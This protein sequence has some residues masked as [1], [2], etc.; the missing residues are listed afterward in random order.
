MLGKPEWFTYRKLGWGI[1]PRSW[2]GFAYAGVFLALVIALAS[3]PLPEN[4]KNIL[5]G[6]VVALFV[7]DAI[8]IWS[9]LGEHHDERQRLHQLIIERNCSVVAV[10]A[11]LAVIMFRAWQSRSAVGGGLP[12]DPLLIAVLGGMALTKLISTIYL[13]MKM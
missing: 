3:S 9:Q 10:I 1:T 8:A 2:Q 6:I 13:Q 11:L 12:F 7:V 5:I 4:T